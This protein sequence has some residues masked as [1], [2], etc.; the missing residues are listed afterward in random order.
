MFAAMATGAVLTICLIYN[1]K[2]LA[3]SRQRNRKTPVQRPIRPRRD[4]SPLNF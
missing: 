4:K 3:R 2:K 1:Q